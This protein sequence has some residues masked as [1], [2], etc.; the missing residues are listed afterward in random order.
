[1]A[2]TASQ[3]QAAQKSPV[4]RTGSPA[5][6]MKTAGNS[7]A[8]EIQQLKARLGSL[9]QQILGLPGTRPDQWQ[10]LLKDYAATA[11]ALYRTLGV[12]LEMQVGQA[13]LKVG[14]AVNINPR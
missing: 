1:M 6:A 8:P 2:K 10:S 13:T 7:V 3:I 5:V 9:H 12:G 11:S 4:N 14:S